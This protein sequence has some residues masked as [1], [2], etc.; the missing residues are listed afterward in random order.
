MQRLWNR[1]SKNEVLVNFCKTSIFL[2]SWSLVVVP[3][4]YLLFCG[5]ARGSRGFGYQNFKR[6]W[7]AKLYQNDRKREQFFS[8]HGTVQ[9]MNHI[10]LLVVKQTFFNSRFSSDVLFKSLTCVISSHK[11]LCQNPCCW[12]FLGNIVKHK[13]NINK[14][15]K[16]GSLIL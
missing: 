4:T 7:Y 8:E 13:H 6:I 12:H 2:Q 5:Y 16:D 3:W 15:I 1:G 9:I 14:I 11:I 10:L